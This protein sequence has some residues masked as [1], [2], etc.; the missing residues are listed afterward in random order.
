MAIRLEKQGKAEGKS[1][2]TR[3]KHI[4]KMLVHIIIIHENIITDL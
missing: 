1:I 4:N 3:R 2:S